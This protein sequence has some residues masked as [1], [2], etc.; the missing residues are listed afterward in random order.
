VPERGPTQEIHLVDLFPQALH[1]LV[2]RVRRVESPSSLN[3]SLLHTLLQTTVHLV[4]DERRVLVADGPHRPDYRLVS[5]REHAGGKM[6]SLLGQLRVAG[7]GL[8]GGQER[9]L[10]VVRQS[11]N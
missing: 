5:G 3:L 4:S 8:A 11:G 7:R 10:R 1:G 6:N 2:Q 9:E